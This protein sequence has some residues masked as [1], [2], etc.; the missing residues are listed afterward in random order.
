MN[1][2]AETE[3]AREHILLTPIYIFW[4]L[5]NSDGEWMMTFF[6]LGI[7]LEVSLGYDNSF[8]RVFAIIILFLKLANIFPVSRNFC[9]TWQC[10]RENDPLI[11]VSGAFSPITNK[12]TATIDAISQEDNAIICAAPENTIPKLMM[13]QD[14]SIFS[15]G[16][17]SSSVRKRMKEDQS[18]ISGN[19]QSCTITSP[20]Q[21]CYSSLLMAQEGSITADP[22][23]DILYM[24]MEQDKSI[25][26][27]GPVNSSIIKMMEDDSAIISACLQSCTTTLPP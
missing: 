9:W 20:P 27:I 8:F 19:P 10:K 18:E 26:Y 21:N 14:K 5:N 11:Q 22:M 2:L 13:E 17:V 12:L 25:I 15:I 24:M 1:F 16:P 6:M 4:C 23:S 7:G 3:L